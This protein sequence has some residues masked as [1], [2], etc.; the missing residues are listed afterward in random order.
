M[1]T[2]W[3]FA[4]RI[5]AALAAPGPAQSFCLARYGG[6]LTVCL[7]SEGTA[8]DLPP[9]PRVL[10]E[11]S[12]ASDGAT[13][14]SQLQVMLSIRVPSYLDPTTGTRRDP[15]KLRAAPDG[16]FETG[17]GDALCELARA[18][19]ATGSAAL[20]PEG[21]FANARDFEFIVGAPGG[22]G[23]MVSLSFDLAVGL[24]GMPD[25]ETAPAVVHPSN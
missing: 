23:A 2:P 7:A 6:P 18:C 15:S 20:E 8:P 4:R 11:L 24:Y 19:A 17:D 9:L 13:S 16:Y 22:D 14:S 10:V 12:G 5:A 25:G 1:R 21:A 3:T